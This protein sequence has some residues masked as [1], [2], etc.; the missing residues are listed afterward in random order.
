[1]IPKDGT[2]SR[3][4]YGMLVQGNGTTQ[5]ASELSIK[6]ASAR[7]LAHKIRNPEA[8]SAKRYNAHRDEAA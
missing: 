3:K 2:L 5:I 1:M 6:I 7:V 4:I 8:V